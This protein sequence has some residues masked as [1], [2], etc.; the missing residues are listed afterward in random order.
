[1]IPAVILADPTGIL[2]S[3]AISIA[4]SA[5]LTVAQALLFPA[6]R[7]QQQQSLLATQTQNRQSGTFNEKQNVPSIAI[8]LGRVKKGGDYVFLE[9]RDGRAYH[10]LVLAAHRIEGVVD[11]YLHDE[12][13]VTQN[14]SGGVLDPVHFTGDDGASGGSNVSLE[15]KVGLDA[16]TTWTDVVA[17]FPEIWTAAHRGDGLAQ[18][19]MVCNTVEEGR[20]LDVFPQQMPAPSVVLDGALVWDPRDGAQNPDDH[21]TW[22]FSRNLALLRMHHLTQPWGGKLT[23]AD[24]YLP[25]W[26]FAANV[27]DEMVANRSEEEEPRYHGGLWFRASDDPVDI[28]E[29]LDIAADMV[30]YERADGTIG[31]HAGVFIPPDITITEKEIFSITVDANRRRSTTVLAVRGRYTEPEQVYATVDAAIFGDPYI[32]DDDSQRTKTVDNAAVQ[33]HNHMQRLQKLAYTRAN[34]QKIQVTVA[35][36]F[37]GAIR[38]IPYRRFVTVDFPRRGLDQAVVEIINRPKLNLETLTYQFDAIVVDASLYDFEA[39]VHEGVPAAT[40]TPIEHTGIPVPEDFA[41]AIERV[42]LVDGRNGSRAVATWTRPASDTGNALLYE[43]EWQPDDESEAPQYAVSRVAENEVRSNYLI[44]GQ[45]YRFRL[46]ARSGNGKSDWTEYLTA[47]VPADFVEPVRSIFDFDAV[48]DGSA[49]DTAAVQAAVDWAKANSRV[50]FVPGGYVFK[51]TEPIDMFL[52]APA[53]PWGMRGEVGFNSSEFKCFFD[54]FDLAVLSGDSPDY[55][56]TVTN[57][58]RGQGPS[59][60]G[61]R[62]TF[63]ASVTQ[64]PVAFSFQRVGNAQLAN[65]SVGASNNT[66][67]RLSNLT[68]TILGDGNVAYGGGWAYDRKATTGITFAI[69]ATGTTLTSSASHFSAE[70]EGEYILLSEGSSEELF[71]IASYTSS[72]SVEVAEAANRTFTTAA[73]GW[74]PATCSTTLDSDLV[75]ATNNQALFTEANSLGRELLFP[76]AGTNGGALRAT[77]IAVTDDHTLQIDRN[78]SASVTNCR[79]GGAAVIFAG[80]TGTFNVSNDFDAGGWQ[81]ENFAGYGLFLA[82]QTRASASG[83]V[84]VHGNPLPQSSTASIGAVLASNTDF[85]FDYLSLDSNCVGPGKL[86]AIGGNKAIS[87]NHLNCTVAQGEVVIYERNNANAALVS[88]DVLATNNQ[89]SGDTRAKVADNEDET[90]PVIRIGCVHDALTAN[91]TMPRDVIGG[92]YKGLIEGTTAMNPLPGFK[93]STVA[94]TVTYAT[95]DGHYWRVD[96]IVHFR[97]RLVVSGISVAPSGN[98]QIDGLPYTSAN[99]SGGFPCSLDTLNFNLVTAGAQITARVGGN[100]KLINL[101]ENSDNAAPV[102]FTGGGGQL[103]T[104]SEITIW[105]SYPIP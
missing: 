71:L 77:V 40:P 54:G 20:F 1:M 38:N 87:V 89:V 16:E 17:V 36:N 6:Q 80:R 62:V 49:D 24:L 19:L 33:S 47:T 43:L 96:R 22:A 35:Y 25:D 46:R 23:F 11:Y 98:I 78:A 61:I 101:T 8:A 103:L 91:L 4:I 53:K 10:I 65:C 55:G 15:S 7:R 32:A 97:I 9:E 86:Q 56:N 84:K 94:G 51:V 90:S 21:N 27:C 82:W 37:F 79:F 85:H 75:V 45:T 74:G 93:G 83:R 99:Y 30:L 104:N 2:I 88:V 41:I 92:V 64:C 44:E 52:A 28:G 70:D 81:I 76:G 48:G 59:L 12:R 63:D 73:G 42:L 100:S 50:V 72:T 26:I 69:S 29:T 57:E 39:A 31:V 105:G 95:Q 58:S 102:L 60:D 18:L 13:V 3:V 68:N 34:A 5:V 66:Q 14:G 67:F